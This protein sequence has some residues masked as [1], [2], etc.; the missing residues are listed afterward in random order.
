MLEIALV[1]WIVAALGVVAL[2]D[3][4]AKEQV[5]KTGFI[6]LV[7]II[8]SAASMFAAS[9]GGLWRFR[10]AKN[11]SSARKPALLCEVYSHRR[12]Q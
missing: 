5:K 7:V 4:S 11:Q 1:L 9:D 3:V 10:V 12:E 6:A 2:V 8:L